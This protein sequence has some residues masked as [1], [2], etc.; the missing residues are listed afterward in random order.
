MSDL[1]GYMGGPRDI[2]QAKAD[3][4]SAAEKAIEAAGRVDTAIDAA[5]KAA[6]N[7]NTAT[8]ET[9]IA[10]SGAEA[11]AAEADA[12]R[13][14][15]NNAAQNAIEK[16]EEARAAGEE[17]T[18]AAE[19]ARQY[20]LGDISEK[21]VTF[22]KISAY[23][24]ITSGENLK[25]MFGKIEKQIAGV[26]DASAIGDGAIGFEKLSS[27]IVNVE[28]DNTVLQTNS[29]FY[30][31]LNNDEIAKEHFVDVTL[32]SEGGNLIRIN[33][34]CLIKNDPWGAKPDPDFD[35]EIHFIDG[36]EIAENIKTTVGVSSFGTEIEIQANHAYT[37]Y[38]VIIKKT[39]N[40][41][42]TI[43]SITAIIDEIKHTEAIKALFPHLKITQENIPNNLITKEKL[44]KEVEEWVEG[45]AA[46]IEFATE[47]EA[48]EGINDHTVMSPL[49]VAQAIDEMGGG[50]GGG[51]VTIPTMTS[52]FTGGSFSVN[53]EIEIRYRWGSPNSGN[54]TLHVLVDS[55]EFTTSEVAQGMNRYTLTGLSKGSH[56]IQMYVVD[57]GGQYT[58]TLKFTIKVGTL[59]ITSPFDDSVDFA[60]TQIIKI[61][62]TIDT[63][64][65]EPIYITRTI[66]N[67]SVRLL[68]QNG[69]NVFQLPT[70]TAGAHKVSFKAESSIYISN[71]LT[72]DIVIEDSDALT[73]ISDFDKTMATYRELVEIQ[74]RVS[75]KGAST[76]KAAYYIDD[77]LNREA[78]IPA[79]TNIWS[80]R[81]LSIG[82]HTLKVVVTTLDGTKSAELSWTLQVNSSSYTP[83][84][85]VVDASLLCWFDA[86]NKTNQDMDRDTW[87][88]KSGNDTP[89]TLY[90]LNYGSNGWIDG[91]LKLNGGAYAEIDLQALKDNAPYGVTVD[92]KFCTR[93]V[94][95]QE[96]CVLDMRGSDSNNKGFAVDTMQMYLNSGTS[97]I[98][99]DIAEEEMSRA[100]FVIDRDNKLA[101]IYNN[102]VL[103]EAFIMGASEDFY[104]T[105]KIYLNTTLGNVN[106]VWQPDIF[107]SCE[108]YSIRVY[109]RALESEEI[110]QN[111]VSD[112]P[113]L[114]AQEEKYNINYKNNMP[115]MYFYG[116][117]S[118]M[119]K[120]N[121]VPLRIKYISPDSTKYGESFDLTDCPVSWQ[122]TSS[123]QYAVKNYK[124]RLRNQGGAKYKY[125][126]FGGILEDTFCLKAD[127]MESSHANN[128][129]MAKFIHHELYNEQTP[130]QK[131]DERCRTTIDGF[132]IQLYIAKDSVSAP[133][134]M[135]V[136]NFNLDKACND[137][138]GMDNTITGFENCCKFEVSS[139]SD[140]SAGAFRDDS[141]LSI[142]EDF[143]V[144]YPDEDDLT[145]D[146]LTEKYATLKRMVSWV[147]NS[148]ETTFKAELDQYF[149]REYLMK[150]FLQAH[151]FGMVD[152]LG[153]NMM[154]CTWDGLIWYPT[155][156]DMDT[157]LGLDNTGYLEFYSDC[158]VVEGVYNTSNS[159]LFVM[160]QTC[161][162]SEL[163]EMYK[164]MRM[165]GKYSVP[166]ILKYW[167]DQQVAVIGES[168][169]NKDMEAKYIQFKNDYLFMLHGR[170]YE[171][172]KKW[173][174]ERLL[175]LDTIYGYEAD[176][177]SSITIRANKAAT[178]SLDI[179]TYSPQY[180]RVKWRNGVEQRLKI[181]RDENGR[182][183]STKFS[184]TL[185]TATDQEV[186]IYNAKQIKKIDGLS[187]LNPSVLNL[188]EASGLTEV[189]CENSPLLADVRLNSANTFLSHINFN[190]CTSL[191]G[192]LDLSVLNNLEY[193]NLNAT[194]LTNISFP[195]GGCNLKELY[196]DIT[197]LSLLHLEKMPLLQTL[198]LNRNAV[199]SE[200]Y[201][202]DCIQ[203]FLKTGRQYTYDHYTVRIL[204]DALRIENIGGLDREGYLIV[205]NE[206]NGTRRMNSFIL[207]NVSIHGVYTTFIGSASKECSV[208]EFEITGCTI[209]NLTLNRLGFTEQH[210]IDTAGFGVI[211]TLRMW[212]AVNVNRINVPSTLKGL[213]LY[214]DS[215]MPNQG[216][217]T[218]IDP[219]TGP[220]GGEAVKIDGEYSSAISIDGTPVGNDNALDLSSFRITEFLNVTG[221]DLSTVIINCDFL[222]M[223]N[224]KYLFRE[225]NAGTTK[226][227]S[228]PVTA[229]V[230]GRLTSTDNAKIWCTAT[231]TAY[232]PMENLDELE[233]DTSE[234]TDFSS[235]FSYWKNLRKFP[236]LDYRKGI[237]FID[238]CSYATALTGDIVISAPQATHLTNVM[239]ETNITSFEIDSTEITSIIYAFYSTRNVQSVK[240]GSTAKARD[241]L[242][243]FNG[244]SKLENIEGLSLASAVPNQTI[245]TQRPDGLFGGCAALPNDNIQTIMDTLKVP[246]SGGYDF[247]NAFNGCKLLTSVPEKVAKYAISIE[248]TFAST[249]IK[250][251]ENITFELTDNAISAF[252]SSGVES[253]NNVSFPVSKSAYRMFYN[254][255][256]LTNVS[257]L[258]MPLVENARETFNGCTTLEIVGRMELSNCKNIFQTFLACGKLQSIEYLDW[259]YAWTNGSSDQPT[260]S[261]TFNG[262]ITNLT[263]V[264]F[265]GTIGKYFIYG[266]P[267]GAVLDLESV[268]SFVEHAAS[269]SSPVTL[270]VRKST[271]EL[272]TE[273]MLTSLAAKNWTIANAGW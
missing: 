134:Y 246:E 148:D 262:A 36:T 266:T 47:E 189:V 38:R 78:T 101:K 182:M 197:T 263:H 60:V 27:E 15:A 30:N 31:G 229:N 40:L 116:D 125:S 122:G 115:T 272:F 22:D 9:Y 222:Q 176:T 56:S 153:K 53:E 185:T 256:K 191:S 43:A 159:K 72:F 143:E 164:S 103:T 268:Q 108:I 98:K 211:K 152:N 121:K 104:N 97:K 199:Y 8:E 173:I 61:P 118:A 46:Y 75:L 235:M 234:V 19:E 251:L 12:A 128:T 156:Y 91:A 94:G 127:Y 225:S 174:T 240:F 95:N 86:S 228:L 245:G 252:Q 261:S 200:F 123:L 80:T 82:R 65:L 193:V 255:T 207:K 132:P 260:N 224:D 158:D 62:I 221:Y 220:F 130:A 24:N 144:T 77:I 181:G 204:A 241:I 136:F 67:E 250:N 145:A 215:Y 180:L 142:R 76:F 258:N 163:A 232:P 18:A 155:F 171:H 89:V 41:N 244:C 111:L 202:K 21:T 201:I 147:K 162:A 194:K 178:V 105:S 186:I 231:A 83:L 74:Y 167:Y 16:A 99:S 85:P 3:A 57:R 71:I 217:Y 64:S 4:E 96:A 188:V 106:G 168:Q 45:K 88:D 63:I 7:A 44:S 6:E 93:D 213:F 257:G 179:L 17:A 183:K 37:A 58:D 126:P 54:G 139:N 230:K 137:T 190:K 236:D 223:D 218:L 87:E 42:K 23:E 11:A 249:G 271:F 68:A 140:T 66:D 265:G 269:L 114:D 177:S 117:T 33:V 239:R 131:L 160:L 32:H 26:H 166:T 2:Q 149:N 264:I 55:I 247:K 233:W 124:I 219:D 248:Y 175:Y 154:L 49:R 196:L 107:G 48:R 150:Y 70:L 129:G 198:I 210:D 192:V 13:D 10:K 242:Q 52:S 119:T 209:D 238:M 29:A 25:T 102:G 39:Y 208:K 92:I 226:R 146:Q 14:N 35:V 141:D 254:C 243:P 135:G 212:G 206:Q 157:Q 170:R 100:T 237:K 169:Y 184:G 216:W 187:N 267:F 50:G 73:L 270:T 138:Y 1:I 112:I 120:D 195:I 172:M 133:V 110:V 165:S 273:E 59:D 5:N 203:L 151:L 81:D 205:N 79:G 28:N 253:V 259:S 109:A 90:N 69:Y 34:K 84:D 161:F 51:I 20:V 214:K 113:D 227:F